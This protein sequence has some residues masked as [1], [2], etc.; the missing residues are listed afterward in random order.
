M[1]RKKRFATAGIFGMAPSLLWSGLAFAADE[2]L[3]PLFESPKDPTNL[4]LLVGAIALITFV[5]AAVTLVRGRAPM[6]LGTAGL[7]LLPAFSYV[8]GDIMVLEDS[9]RVEFCGSCHVTMGPVLDAMKNGEPDT[10]AALHFQRGRI[11][12]HDACYECHSGYGIWGTAH[13]KQAGIMHMINTVTGNYDLPLKHRGEF[14]IASCLNCHAATTNFREQLMH[15]DPEV[16]EA[17]L[18][19]QI[20]CAG[21]CHATAHPASALNGA[22]AG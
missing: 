4:W 7:F 9:K 6:V 8:V 16:Q 21:V 11:S 19:G 14:D 5:A 12:H 17:L 15:R 22:D 13:A 20:S 18:T 10:L 1:S 2:D 3:G